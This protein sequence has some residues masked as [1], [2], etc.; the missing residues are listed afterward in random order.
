MSTKP[1][2]KTWSEFRSL[3]SDKDVIFFGASNDWTEKT[4]SRANIN[5]AACVD[6]DP[7]IVG[8]K[9]PGSQG[10]VI[11][12]PEE[13]LESFSRDEYV[14]ITSG[15]YHSIIPQLVGLG[16]QPGEDFCV[17]PALNNLRVI[18]DLDSHEAELLISSPDHK[19][20]SELDENRDIGGGLYRYNIGNRECEKLLD[21]TFHQMVNAGD[22]YY[23]ADEIRG[24]CRVSKDYELLDVFGEEESADNHGIAYSEDRELVFISRTGLDKVAAFDP[25]TKSKEFEIYLSDKAEHIHN[26]KEISEARHWGNDLHVRD[27]Y[28][29]VSMFSHSGCYPEGV[30]DG[31]ILQISLKDLDVR[32]VLVRDAWMPHTVRFFDS[33]ICYLDSMN[34]D[35]YKSDKSVVGEFQGFI[36][37]LDFDGSYYYVGQS[38]SRYPARQQHEEKHVAMTAGIY[39]FDEETTASKFYPVP[40]VRQ[41]HDVL[42][43][44]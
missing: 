32:N 15:A 26:S 30:Y 9:R 43:I 6:N 21:G 4:I 10:I 3:V 31:G 1:F 14:V 33:D 39:M 37:G 41:I 18:A 28:L 16:L 44:E 36:R 11:E 35:F 2:W 40:K 12:S 13:R 29:Y 34:G 8:T 24:I 7:T 27:D 17:S 38:E 42:V 19:I 25:K 23:V 20:Y 22:S 5:L